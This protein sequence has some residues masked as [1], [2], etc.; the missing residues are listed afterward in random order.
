MSNMQIYILSRINIETE[1]EMEIAAKYFPLS[2]SRCDIPAGSIIIPRYSALPY[3][4]ELEYD[5]NK[6]GGK[7]IQTYKQHQYIANF[8][9]YEDIKEYTFKTW[10]L[11]DISLP[12]IPLVVKGKTNSKKWAWNKLM[13]APNKLEA[14]KIAC[15]LS[16]D[17]LISNQGIIFR[18]YIPLY[19]R[20]IGINGLPFTDE[21]RFFFLNNKEIAA[22]FYWSIAENIEY[23]VPR[24]ARELANIISNIVYKKTNFYVI[25]IA[26]TADNN[27]LCVELNCGTM[28]G[29]STIDAD[30][31][32][33]C[34]RGEL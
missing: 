13:F 12:N 14:V 31:F 32:Y 22:G 3:Y 26:R 15:N 10:E 28:S 8:E 11:G 21:Y 29:L 5:V 34:L 1:E 25:D 6:L 30:A 18:E 7:L 9:Y 24:E 27:W 2:T 17:G 16:N 4:N 20:E 33:K 23:S 19:T